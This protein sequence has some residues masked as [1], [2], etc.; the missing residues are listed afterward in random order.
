MLENPT[1]VAISAPTSMATAMPSAICMGTSS[2]P[3]SWAVQAAANPSTAAS[4]RLP[5]NDRLTTP[6]RSVMVSPRLAITSGVAVPTMLLNVLR[7]SSFIALTTNCKGEAAT[8][9]HTNRCRATAGD[10]QNRPYIR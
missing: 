6:A 9:P 2:T 8:R 5:S 3:A 7:N 1:R 10:S 4:A